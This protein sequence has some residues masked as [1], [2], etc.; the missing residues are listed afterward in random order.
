LRREFSGSGSGKENGPQQIDGIGA[1]RDLESG[2]HP[3]VAAAVPP[4]RQARFCFSPGTRCSLRGRLLLAPPVHVA[5]SSLSRTR[6]IGMRKLRRNREQDRAVGRELRR[7]GWRVVRIWHHDLKRLPDSRET[8]T[9]CAHAYLI[10]STPVHPMPRARGAASSSEL[11]PPEPVVQLTPRNVSHV[12]L[13][14][15]SDIPAA[16]RRMRVAPAATHRRCRGAL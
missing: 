14:H 11:Q 2:R 5:Q 13:A 15:G 9:R 7:L 10:G 16:G 4:A 3:R 12:L 6:T 8:N 1:D